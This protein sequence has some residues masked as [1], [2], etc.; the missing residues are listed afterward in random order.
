MSLSF[1]VFSSTYWCLSAGVLCVS[2]CAC[3]YALIHNNVPV[4]L[5]LGI[6]LPFNSTE[7]RCLTCLYLN[8][9]PSPTMTLLQQEL[10]FLIKDGCGNNLKT[11][12]CSII[13]N[14]DSFVHHTSKD[15]CSF[16]KLYGKEIHAVENSYVYMSQTWI[17]PLFPQLKLHFINFLTATTNFKAIDLGLVNYSVIRKW[18]INQL[19]LIESSY[20]C[21]SSVVTLLQLSVSSTQRDIN[22]VSSHSAIVLHVVCKTQHANNHVKHHVV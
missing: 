9:H 7:E 19:G 22:T 5:P 14:F 13:F 21:V 17:C 1:V 11:V 8:L 20:L 15:Q 4:D 10:L 18:Q 6:P 2:V 12:H 16:V 3:V